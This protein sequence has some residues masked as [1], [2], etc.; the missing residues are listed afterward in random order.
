M[1]IGRDSSGGL[2]FTPSFGAPTFS[3]A[4]GAVSDIFAAQGYRFKAE[5]DLI[6]GQNYRAAS[7]LALQ[8]EEFTKESTQVKLA[9]TQ[10]EIYKQLGE[11]QADV[12]AAGF[13]MSGSGLDILREG[14]AQGALTKQVLGQQGLI[15]EAGYEEQAG[16]YANMASA[17]DIAAK[18]EKTAATGAEI[19]GAIK[20]VAA[21]ATLFV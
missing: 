13:T 8:N 1:P 10:R 21:V 15:T 7:A 19:S 9:Q 2:S 11:T 12:G 17:A 3:D 5:G 6:E 16:A 20:G 14:A 4:A 18:A